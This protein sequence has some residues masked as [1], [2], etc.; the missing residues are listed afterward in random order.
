[1]HKLL[2]TWLRLLIIVLNSEESACAAVSLKESI[3]V[4]FGGQPGRAPPPI[5]EVGGQRYPFAPKIE[6]KFLEN[7]E[8]TSEKRQR[9]Q[10]LPEIPE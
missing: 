2:R 1:M 5:I 7:I 6:I 3:G 9:T 8:T 10:I 4:D